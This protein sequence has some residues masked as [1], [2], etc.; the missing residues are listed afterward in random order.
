MANQPRVA[1]VLFSLVVSMAIGAIVLLMLDG[2]PL[3]GG[4]FSLSSYSHLNSVEQAITTRAGLERHRWNRIEVFYSRTAG[5]NIEQLASLMG[6]PNEDEVNFHFLICNGR[7]GGDGQINATQKWINQ[8]SCL[9]GGI[10]Y[11]SSQTIRIC[12]TGDGK[13]VLSTD[14]QIKRTSALIE[15]LIRK[16]EIIPRH[17]YYPA[18]W[19]F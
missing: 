19:Q 8:W 14:S 4:A 7:G 15:A 10:W 17:V 1:K 5:G 9:P 2:R 13:K 18:N 12:L 11:G 3:P 16:Y 6:L